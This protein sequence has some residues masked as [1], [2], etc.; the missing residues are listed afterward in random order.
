MSCHVIK[1]LS[2]ASSRVKQSENKCLI[3]KIGPISYPETSVRNHH[4]TLCNNP[5]ECRFQMRRHISAR[6]LNNAVSLKYLRRNQESIFNDNDKLPTWGRGVL[7]KPVVSYLLVFKKSMYFMDNYFIHQQQPQ[8]SI[9]SPTNPVH[10]RYIDLFK[11]SFNF[12]LPSS[13]RSC[14]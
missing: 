5:E 6:G 2:V 9:L 12:I 8:A 14:K 3:P 10:S 7:G 1:Y 11:T 13:P 4:F